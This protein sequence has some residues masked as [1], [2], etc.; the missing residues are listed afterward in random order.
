MQHPSVE[1]K[2]GGIGRKQHSLVIIAEG[3]SST[4][5]CAVQLCPIEVRTIVLCIKA[6]GTLI[7]EQGIG[8]FFQLKINHATQI[9]KFCIAF[10]FFDGFVGKV[11]GLFVLLRLHQFFGLF[12]KSF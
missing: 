12:Q 10:I 3:F 6:D 11:Q 1:I 4:A 2:V 7:V 8:I 5:L 9:E